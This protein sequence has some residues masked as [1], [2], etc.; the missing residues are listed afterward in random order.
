MRSTDIR[1]FLVDALE[2]DLIGPL[3]GGERLDELSG[4]VLPERPSR[5][6]LTGFLVPSGAPEDQ[7]VDDSQDEQLDQVSGSTQSD[8][9]DTPDKSSALK[10]FFPSS[11]GVSVLVPAEVS[12]LEASVSWG[13]YTRE[14][15]RGLEE[16]TDAGVGKGE[17]WQRTSHEVSLS[18]PVDITESTPRVVSVPGYSGVELIVTSREVS[19]QESLGGELIPVGTRSVSVF[20]VNRQRH[21]ENKLADESFM[22]QVELVLRCSRSGFVTRPN[23]RGRSDDSELDERIADLQ[24]RHHSE[25]GVGHGVATHAKIVRRGPEDR[26]VCHELAT[27][28]IPKASV[29]RVE[30]ATV[31]CETRMEVLGD[32]GQTATQLLHS[33]SGLPT[34]YRAWIEATFDG[35]QF[36]APRHGDIAETLKDRAL[37]ALARIERGIALLGE[38]EDARIAFQI[39]N[40]VMARA[41]RQRR[42]DEPRWRIFQLAFILMNLCSM[43][44]VDDRERE[45]VDLIFFPTGGGKTEAYLG[46]AAY[47]LVLRRLRHDGEVLSCGVSVIMRYTLRLLTLDQ[48]ERAAAMI[49]ALELERRGL[50]GRGFK[51]LGEWPFEIGLW[52]GSGATPNILGDS[53]NKRDYTALGKLESFVIDPD[54]KPSPIPL[55]VCPWCGSKFGNKSFKAHPDS[56][57]P[58]D[59]HVRCLNRRCDVNHLKRYNGQ[60]FG[61]LPIVAI[62]EPLYRRLPCFIISTVDKFANLPWVGRTGALFG[63]VERYDGNGFYGPTD[64]RVA[65]QNTLERALDPPDLIIQDELHLISGPVGTMVGLYETVIE[66]LCERDIEGVSHRPKIIASTATIRRAS[67]HIRA[68]FARDQVE[69]FPPQGPD[70]RDSFF[71]RT[72]EDPES[73]RLYIGVAAQGR[74]LK[75]LL[76]RTYLSLMS[77]AQRAFEM[78]HE[79]LVASGEADAMNPADPYMTLVGYFNSLREL[80]GSRRIVEDEIHARLP[81][82]GKRLRVDADEEED[83]DFANRKI[84]FEP[85]ELTSRVS[86][87]Q[88]A[89]AKDR[90]TNVFG[91]D[92]QTVDV[93]LASNMISVG[94]DIVRL[95]LM[96][97]LGQPK[98]AAEYIQATSRVGRDKT[99]PGLV[100]TLLNTHRPRD[101]SH[102]ER[103]EAFHSTIYRHVEATSITP[104]ASRALQRGLAGVTVALARHLVTE[105]TPS[106]GAIR[107]E[108]FRDE[109]ARAGALLAERAVHAGHP[110]TRT[111]EGAELFSKEITSYVENLLDAWVNKAERIQKE[112]GTSK[113]NYQKYE[114]S[115]SGA[116]LLYAPLE[117]ELDELEHG[118]DRKFKA[119]RSLR[120]VEPS[121]NLRVKDLYKLDEEV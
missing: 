15:L 66:R 8:D 32:D 69:I 20:V 56:K 26:M 75:V 59:L 78:A 57:S 67:S 36:E 97:V 90:L 40:R 18:L 116:R 109:V 121:V 114:G 65:G 25:F 58:I 7:R 93:A 64:P 21:R 111:E 86:T 70:I 77:A 63:Q 92:K 39:A 35:A 44:H 43:R 5:W 115:R 31:G 101:R 98:S 103:F 68:L 100:V 17:Q 102:Y 42:D 79:V 51:R 113:L 61:Q 73:A 41:A 72:I 83:L 53:K 99:R 71:A 12:T 120:S 11:I 85:V 52:V 107:I 80:G 108:E 50:E 48:L 112:S 55:E 3:M 84:S 30:P 19:A 95:G 6:Y 54:H 34:A 118:D 117:P 81:H 45:L 29:Y 1:E 74:S 10:H 38:D 62:D 49:I 4:E 76:L 24:Y 47:T 82:Y 16:E 89:Q 94:L 27:S 14:R 60:P 28:W 22:F 119:Q 2:R 106:E 88:I 91:K 37:Y 46:L 33:L 104:F 23:P 105:M 13:S 110:D 96:V 9:D 87:N